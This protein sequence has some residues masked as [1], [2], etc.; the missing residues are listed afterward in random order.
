MQ[1]APLYACAAF[2][3]CT[4]N[5]RGRKGVIGMAFLLLST[6]LYRFD[7]FVKKVFYLH[8]L[9]DVQ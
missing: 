2:L 1:M 9:V 4:E 5:R 7:Y 3:I 8:F 6:N